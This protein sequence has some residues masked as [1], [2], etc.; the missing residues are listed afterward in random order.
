MGQLLKPMHPGEG[1]ANELPKH[2][3]WKVT[4]SCQTWGKVQ[5]AMITHSSQNK[6]INKIIKDSKCIYF[7]KRKFGFW[8]KPNI[9]LF[10]W[11]GISDSDLNHNST[12]VEQERSLDCG[13]WGANSRKSDEWERINSVIPGQ[14]SQGQRESHTIHR[15]W[16]TLKVWEFCEKTDI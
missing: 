7:K 2:C 1:K 4:P 11:A 6:T 12:F 9:W 10:F 15:V 16:E 5:V 3:N 14:V 8:K 13:E